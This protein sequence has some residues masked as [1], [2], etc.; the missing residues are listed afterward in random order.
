MTA[1]FPALALWFAAGGNTAAQKTERSSNSRQEP[2][3]L[4]R[5]N[6]GQHFKAT[7]GQPVVVTLETW[8]RAIRH[9]TSLFARRPVRGLQVRT[10]TG[11]ESRQ[12]E[13]IPIHRD[14]RG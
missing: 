2:L 7:V 1:I 8:C 6:D 5:A 13:G 3:Q 11:T 4:A 14:C 10:A 12:S 9:A